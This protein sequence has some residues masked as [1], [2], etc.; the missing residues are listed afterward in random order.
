MTK[1]S[2]YECFR[3][4][5]HSILKLIAPNSTSPKILFLDRDGVIIKDVHYINNPDHVTL[6]PGI[7][8][9][10][11]AASLH[12]YLSIIVTNQS[13]IARGLSTFD[14]YLAVTKKMIS[15]IPTQDLPQYILSSFHHPSQNEYPYSDWRKPGTGMFKHILNNHNVDLSKSIMVGDKL[16]DLIPAESVGIRNIFYLKSNHHHKE[17]PKLS[18]WFG[19][20]PLRATVCTT[21]LPVKSFLEGQR[22]SESSI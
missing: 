8:S 4:P 9:C 3:Y 5:T 17:L 19:D 12:G 7:L 18:A 1:L 22:R 14:Q 2:H 15:L 21:L 16:T 20:R 10:L 6:I 13:S 11:R